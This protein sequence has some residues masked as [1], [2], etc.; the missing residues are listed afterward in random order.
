LQ[1]RAASYFCCC[2]FFL[3]REISINNH[4]LKQ[5]SKSFYQILLKLNKFKEIIM[6][7]N[8]LAISVLFGFMLIV[9]H[10][11]AV[12]SSYSRFEQLL[13][14]L[15]SDIELTNEK[16]ALKIL[17]AKNEQIEDINSQSQR[18]EIGNVIGKNFSKRGRRK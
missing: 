5:V 18:N 1:L 3:N 2:R 10:T 9:Q 6:K 8:L 4:F 16:I 15:K 7:A 17:E 12:P 11:N 13:E 14:A